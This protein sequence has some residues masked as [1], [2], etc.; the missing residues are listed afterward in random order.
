MEDKVLKFDN[1]FNKK[2]FEVKVIGSDATVTAADETGVIIVKGVTLAREETPMNGYLFPFS[3]L[4]ANPEIW[5]NV[6]IFSP[7]HID[8]DLE[9]QDTV[10]LFTHGKITNARAD[11]EKRALVADLIFNGNKLK[12]NF[13]NLRDRILAGKPVDGSIAIR[14]QL[15]DNEGE[16]N[17]IKYFY[18]VLSIYHANHY[19]V[20]PTLRGACS[21]S[22]NKPCGLNVNTQEETVEK[23]TDTNQDLTE[24]FKPVVKMFTEAITAAKETTDATEQEQT[25]LTFNDCFKTIQASQTELDNKIELLATGVAA[26]QFQ[27]ETLIKNAADT[28]DNVTLLV[29]SQATP[30]KGEKSI[31]VKE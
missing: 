12:E 1:Q 17:E 16:L 13:P 26:I 6:P 3:T 29:N 5:N 20:L 22:H 7:T 4:A 9:I 21:T 27:I 25:Q 14:A 24:L 11:E 19:A 31:F 28:G 18:E 2:P 8:P 10:E 15:K 23:S 30:I